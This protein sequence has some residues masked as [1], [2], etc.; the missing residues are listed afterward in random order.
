MKVSKHFKISLIII[1]I[2]TLIVGIIISVPF[3]INTNEQCAPFMAGSAGQMIITNKDES[4]DSA[5]KRLVEEQI[6]KFVFPHRCFLGWISNYTIDDFRGITPDKY[7]S[8]QPDYEYT[9]TYS[10][11]PTWIGSYNVWMPESQAVTLGKDGW[12]RHIFLNMNIKKMNHN[13]LLVTSTG[14]G[15]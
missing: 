14:S 15:G 12:V 11:K 9:L 8:I 3:L 1:A 10:V 7:L 6:T 13:V 5:V 2:C 4:V